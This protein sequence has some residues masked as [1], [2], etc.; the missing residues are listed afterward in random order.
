MSCTDILAH[1]DCK[2]CISFCICSCRS[3]VSSVSASIKIFVCFKKKKK[4]KKRIYHNKINSVCLIWSNSQKNLNH[5]LCN[6]KASEPTVEHG[7][8]YIASNDT[9]TFL[10]DMF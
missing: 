3:I 1:C 2:K 10:E 6:I 9:K 5:T 4:K 8:D 7:F